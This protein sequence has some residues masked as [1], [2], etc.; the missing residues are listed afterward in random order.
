LEQASRERQARWRT[1]LRTRSGPAGNS[2]RR[3]SFDTHPYR[4]NVAFDQQYGEGKELKPV[5]NSRHSAPA[6]S[7]ALM[8]LSYHT[9]ARQTRLG[10]WVNKFSGW[11]SGLGL[12]PRSQAVLEV[13]GRTSRRTRS[14]PLVIAT[15]DGK[16]TSIDAGFGI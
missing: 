16:C 8:R 6:E 5:N 15:V 2:L 4:W 12:P 10:R 13:H 3:N 7:S 9:G 11:W 1:W 14:S